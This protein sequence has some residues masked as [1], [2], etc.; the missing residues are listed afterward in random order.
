[1]T[2]LKD[3]MIL[4]TSQEQ[5]GDLIMCVMQCLEMTDQADLSASL[6]HIRGFA[7]QN[8]GN[9]KDA[10]MDFDIAL[11]LS[12]STKTLLPKIDGCMKSLLVEYVKDLFGGK[13]MLSLPPLPDNWNSW[14][15]NKMFHEFQMELEQAK[16]L[17]KLACD[18]RFRRN[19]QSRNFCPFPFFGGHEDNAEIAA[20]INFAVEGQGAHLGYPDAIPGGY[21]PNDTI[22]VMY[23]KWALLLS[24]VFGIPHTIANAFVHQKIVVFNGLPIDGAAKQADKP[25]KKSGGSEDE[26]NKRLE[27][28]NNYMT[29]REE[30]HQHTLEF[31]KAV[32]KRLKNLKYM[33]VY[34]QDTYELISKNKH[35]IPAGIQLLQSK[36]IIHPCT[37]TPGFPYPQQESSLE[38]YAF[39]H[40]QL[41]ASYF[42]VSANSIEITPGILNMIFGDDAIKYSKENYQLW[43]GAPTAGGKLLLQRKNRSKIAEKIPIARNTIWNNLKVKVGK[44]KKIQHSPLTNAKGESVNSLHISSSIKTPGKGKYFNGED[45]T[46]EGVFPLENPTTKGKWK[47][48]GGKAWKGN[49]ALYYQDQ[50]NDDS[51]TINENESELAAVVCNH[52]LASALMGLSK[53]KLSNLEKLVADGNNVIH[54]SDGTHLG[55]KHK[56]A[57]VFTGL[58]P[59]ID[60]PKASKLPFPNRYV[61]KDVWTRQANTSMLEIMNAYHD[62]R[63]E[64]KLYRDIPDDFKNGLKK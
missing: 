63:H 7:R 47:S 20:C 3:Q 44:H 33:L 48:K 60:C 61:H 22:E 21:A 17:M 31:F 14:D 27:E 2:N 16:P 19:G 53:D 57:A 5:W 1:M 25:K 62:Q 15:H 49:V 9:I 54:A 39:A 34:S 46:A 6:L 59:S 24:T 38:Y 10:M 4:N 36:N 8:L 52:R 29:L 50:A 28:Y 51:D 30:A 43:D 13:L 23:S 58:E 37:L 56:F 41:L 26:Y 18:P 40:I 64:W 55:K 11:T 45:F 32:F 12:P 35:I 42:R